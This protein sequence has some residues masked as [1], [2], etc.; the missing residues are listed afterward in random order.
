[1][2]NKWI[3]KD[4]KVVILSGND[5]GQTGVV[6]GRRKDRIVVQG[7]NVRKKHVRQQ[8]KGKGEI[9]SIEMPIHISNVA[10]CDDED[11]PIRPKVAMNE[12]GSKE[13]YYLKNNEKKVIRTIK[14]K[15][16]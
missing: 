14:K 1:M 8:Q 5:R 2:N 3:R 16:Q 13:L 7:V 10:L 11:R 12:D 15:R 4:D 6:L 9:V